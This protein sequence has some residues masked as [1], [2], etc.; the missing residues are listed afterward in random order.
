M[1]VTKVELELEE[2]FKASVEDLFHVLIEEQVRRLDEL[3]KIL[4]DT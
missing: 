3:F 2:Q 4:C 1:K